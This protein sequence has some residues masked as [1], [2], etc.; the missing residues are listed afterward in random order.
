MSSLWSAFLT[1]QS[2]V[3]KVCT[4]WYRK[5]PS[6]ART[7]VILLEVP[8]QVVQERILSRRLCSKCGVEYNLISHRPTVVGVCDLCGGRL[9][10]RADDTPQAVQ[11]RLRDY[12]D[13][14]RRS[15]SCS[16]PRKLSWRSTRPAR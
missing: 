10:T 9:V 5:T 3:S 11:S 13:K 7:A 4:A 2:K 1:C 6:S 15:W 14:T 8:D 12:H 16:A